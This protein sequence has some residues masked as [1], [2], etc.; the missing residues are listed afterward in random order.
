MSIFKLHFTLLIEMFSLIVMSSKGALFG[1][2][3]QNCHHID[4]CPHKYGRKKKEIFPHHIL[5]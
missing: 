4:E 1:L 5:H 2:I 3:E